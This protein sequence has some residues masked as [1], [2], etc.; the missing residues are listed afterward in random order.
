MHTLLFNLLDMRDLHMSAIPDFC[1]LCLTSALLLGVP[2][3]PLLL[4]QRI[5]SLKRRGCSPCQMAVAIS[6]AHPG[7]C[8]GIGVGAAWRAA[9]DMAPVVGEHLCLNWNSLRAA[10]L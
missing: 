2:H 10:R 3:L 8:A 7:C 1:S 4:C 5:W 9:G 6:D